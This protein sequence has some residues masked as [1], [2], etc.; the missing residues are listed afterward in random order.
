[1]SDLTVRE[2]K[3][4]D[5]DGWDHWLALQPWGSP[6]SASWWL[7]ANCR[8]FGG[9][10]LL[11]GV[12]DGEQLMG[13][14]A[15]RI[16]D[17]GPLH[18]V[19]PANIYNP[20][21]IALGSQQ[22]RQRVLVALLEDMARR[23]LIVRPLTCTPDMVD[24]RGAAWHHWDLTVAWTVVQALKT[25][26][27]DDVSRSELKKMRKAQRAGVTAG[28][29][30]LDADILYDFIHATVLRHAQGGTPTGNGL[31]PGERLLTRERL[32]ILIEAAGAHGMQVVVRDVDGTPLSADFLMFLGTRVAYAI[33]GGSS[34]IGLT[35]GAAVAMY[36]FMLK[37]LR[38]RGYEYLDWCDA[39]QPGY[40]DFKLEFGGTL[41]TRLAVS[42]EPQ[43][44]TALV[45][46]HV[47]LSRLKG[48]LRRH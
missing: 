39:S 14:V 16:T 17:V 9:H 13:G 3:Q 44:L 46:V 6:F 35:K 15:L 10:P 28:V 31:L 4:Q 43:W 23:R 8:A 42:R 40:S 48:L 38:A 18:V 30:P 5:W 20:V 21:V 11:L 36:V 26:T 25:W 22:S 47:R 33:W 12:L 1:M 34:A 29:E 24:L 27:L 7:D 37:E 2:L 45:P 41:T 32:H 19:R